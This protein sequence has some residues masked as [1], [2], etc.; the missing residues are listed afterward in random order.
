MHDLGFVFPQA[1]HLLKQF[2][3]CMDL[4]VLCVSFIM[5]VVFPGKNSH[6][7]LISH[8]VH[9][10][11]KAGG[12]GKPITTFNPTLARDFV[13]KEMGE[14]GLGKLLSRFSSLKGEQD[15]CV[16]GIDRD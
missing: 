15:C 13:R 14:Q 2:L 4:S 5:V 11:E 9:D 16:E 3:H 7:P 10:P 12:A 6:L 1:Q 8:A